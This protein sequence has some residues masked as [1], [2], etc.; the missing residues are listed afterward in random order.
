MTER[1][2]VRV[3]SLVP[4]ATETLLALG[5][6][7]VAC[8]RFCEQPG[9]R[10]VGGTKNPDVEA[11]VALAPDVVVVDEEENR[12]EDAEALTAAGLELLVTAVRDVAGALDAVRAL[13]ARTGRPVPDLTVPAPAPPTARRAFVPIWR[14]P[15]MSVNADTYGA[16]VLR[17]AGVELV[18]A[19]VA[20]ALPDD[21]ARRRRSAVSRISCWCRASRTRSPRRTSPSCARCSR[22]QRRPRRRSGPVLV[23]RPH[24]GRVAR[25]SATAGRTTR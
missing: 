6:D 20:G 16:S 19:D 1:T 24:A 21:R 3:V 22:A 4:S 15:W 11:I 13:A 12:L 9:L 17:F 8:T 23:G 7:V 14:R 10:H 25:L 18:T 5:A 2:A